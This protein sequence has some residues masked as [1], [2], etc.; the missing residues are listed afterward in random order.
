MT[1]WS[2]STS[3]Y[4][5]GIGSMDRTPTWISYTSACKPHCGPQPLMLKV[6]Q[7][8]AFLKV[9]R[10]LAQARGSGSK[11]DTAETNVSAPGSETVRQELEKRFSDLMQRSQRCPLARRLA[12]RWHAMRKSWLPHILHCYDMPGLPRSNLDLESIFGAFLGLDHSGSN[13]L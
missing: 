3:I 13:V 6:R 9:E 8:Y 2:V 11:P 1:G 10:Y 7:V 5:N 12:R 4:S